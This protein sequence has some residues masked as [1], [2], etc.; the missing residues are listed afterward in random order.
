M[1]GQALQ[2]VQKTEI[3]MAQIAR[4][5]PAAAPSL[6]S[7]QQGIRQAVTGMRAALK[8][9]MTSPGQSEPQAPAIGG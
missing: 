5:F 1:L 4:Q 7:A 2:V 6:L 9:I 8:Q 3:Q